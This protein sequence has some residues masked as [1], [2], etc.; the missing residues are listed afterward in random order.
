[1]ASV[2]RRDLDTARDFGRHLNK[3][4]L[5]QNIN[6]DVATNDILP[7]LDVSEKY[8]LAQAKQ[9][10]IS[11]IYNGISQL[12]A[13]NPASLP[14][15][16][17][18]F[19]STEI[20]PNASTSGI[21]IMTVNVSDLPDGVTVVSGSQFTANYS[22]VYNL[23]FS[24]QLSKNAAVAK[25]AEIFL[26]KNGVDVPNTNTIVN[27]AGSQ[28]EHVAAW[29][30]LVPLASGEYAQLAWYSNESSMQLLAQPSGSNPPRPAV[31]SLI[32][33]MTLV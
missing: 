32:V 12:I 27:V 17:G 23:Q 20:Q 22:G 16:Y 30:F 6:N 33:T 1:M 18:A 8:E 25:K 31:P 11:G 5:L 14:R 19:S 21:N 2:Q 3:T 10:S 28:A 26:R 29:N 4:H 9:V 24:A 15:P 13:A 7:I